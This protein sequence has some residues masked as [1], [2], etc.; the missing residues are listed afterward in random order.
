MKT[1]T[2]SSKFQVVIPEEIR[3]KVELKAK[4]KLVVIEKDGVIHL[5]PQRPI[6][7]LRGFLKGLTGE[8]LRDEEDRI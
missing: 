4:Q 3:R 1:V 5:I 2:V 7:E 6:K 8:E